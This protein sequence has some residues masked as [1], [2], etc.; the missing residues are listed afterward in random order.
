MVRKPTTALQ[1]AKSVGYMMM[2]NSE[3]RI[4]QW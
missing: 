4:S 2:K 1:Q 3:K